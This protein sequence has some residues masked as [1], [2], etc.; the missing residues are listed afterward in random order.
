MLFMI[1]KIT[2][3]LQTKNPNYHNFLKL[4]YFSYKIILF[5]EN[6]IKRTNSANN[7]DFRYHREYISSSWE[8]LCDCQRRVNKFESLLCRPSCDVA[9]LSQRFNLIEFYVNINIL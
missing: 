7:C 6:I 5:K 3:V 9:D 2:N 1:V 4:F 8:D